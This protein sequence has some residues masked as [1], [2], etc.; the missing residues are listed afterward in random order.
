M[1]DGDID[2]KP[3]TAGAGYTPPAAGL[4][5]GQNSPHHSDP[6][7]KLEQAARL[8]F[9]QQV[10]SRCRGTRRA[11]GEF[12]YLTNKWKPTVR[13]DLGRD[14]PCS[15][16]P[17]TFKSWS[18]V[19]R[20]C[21]RALDGHDVPPDIAKFRDELWPQ[22]HEKFFENAVDSTEKAAS[23][24]HEKQQRMA[25]KRAKLLA[26]AAVRESREFRIKQA[27]ERIARYDASIK[28]LMTK[29]HALETRRKRAARS[30]AALKRHGE[31]E[32]KA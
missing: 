14:P 30:I 20:L 7:P 16:R 26:D 12:D 3:Y 28:K 22:V 15:D 31:K 10:Y 5:P 21:M 29:V 6:L 9:A 18:H 11:E 2:G 13:E 27:E 19:Y 8:K 32:G 17:V 1:S 24:K 4:A 23:N 25:T